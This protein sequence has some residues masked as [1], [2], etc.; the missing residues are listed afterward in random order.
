MDKKRLVLASN[1]K[2]KIR[3]FKALFPDYDVVAYGDLGITTEPDETGKTFFENAYIKAK[4]ISDL[5]GEIVIADEGKTNFADMRTYFKEI[6]NRFRSV[7]N[8]V[9]HKV[10]DK[11]VEGCNSSFGVS[12]IGALSV[13]TYLFWLKKRKKK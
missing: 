10:E 3:E 9:E 13:A 8:K 4:T 7:K 11:I 5:T 2:G 6:W 12:S 1:N